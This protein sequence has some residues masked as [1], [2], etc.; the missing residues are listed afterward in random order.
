MNKLFYFF[1]LKKI[2]ILSDYIITSYLVF[3][4]LL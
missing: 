2:Q 3:F 1:K 4:L